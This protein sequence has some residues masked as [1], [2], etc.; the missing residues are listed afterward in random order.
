MLAVDKDTGQ[1]VPHEDG[2]PRRLALST[3]FYRV[4]ELPGTRPRA[5]SISDRLAHVRRHFV[6]A[7]DANPEQLKYWTEKCWSVRALNRAHDQ[8]MAPWQTARSP[9]AV[10]KWPPRNGWRRHTGD[11]RRA[12]RDR[13]RAE[14]AGAGPGPAGTREKALATLNR[15]WDGITAHRDYPMISIDNNIAASSHPRPGGDQEE[16]LR[17]A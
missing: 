9:P 8:L 13:R 4:Y 17:L 11:G 1:L 15:E 5:W 6:R 3:D 2:G 7:G 10:R 14:E 16:R 12:R